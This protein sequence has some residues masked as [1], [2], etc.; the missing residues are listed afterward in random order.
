M[1]LKLGGHPV[2]P[3]LVHFPIALWTMGAAAD[4]TGWALPQPWW[5]QI[6]FWSQALGVASGA[7][8]MLAGVL[9]FAAMP[10]DHAG[11]DSAISHFLVMCTAWLLFLVSLALR[12]VPQGSGPSTWAVATAIAGFA[13]MLWG[14]WLGGQ[15]VY[16]FGV[17]VDRPLSQ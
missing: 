16:R 14:G 2:H 3:L 5:W 9:D 13:T 15:L 8:A 4:V 7:L 10:R 6:S 12:G 1:N 17:G 11:R